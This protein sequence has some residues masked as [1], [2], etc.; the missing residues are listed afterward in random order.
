MASVHQGAIVISLPAGGNLSTKQFYF[1]KMSGTGQQVTTCTAATDIP[2]GVLQNKPAAAGRA[3][4]LV[5]CGPTKISADAAL[6]VG[7]LI[8]TS[9]DGQADP[10]T[11]GTD[12]TEYICGQVIELAGAAGDIVEAIIN[13]INPARAA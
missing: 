9:A 4:K 3:A 11:A 2:V 1:M 10:K 13:C 8:G 5:V 6:T 7:T 12:T